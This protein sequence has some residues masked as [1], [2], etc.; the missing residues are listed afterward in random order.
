MMWR[1]LWN[2]MR[3]RSG[4]QPHDTDLCGACLKKA[5]EDL[6]HIRRTQQEAEGHALC[7]RSWSRPRA[8]KPTLI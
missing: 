4:D 8:K 5:F 3:D 2:N 7:R 6:V 1:P